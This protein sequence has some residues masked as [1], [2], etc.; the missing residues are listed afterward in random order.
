M[1]VRFTELIDQTNACLMSL[2]EEFGTTQKIIIWH[3]TFEKLSNSE[4]EAFLHW[5]CNGGVVKID[6]RHGAKKTEPGRVSVCIEKGMIWKSLGGFAIPARRKARRDRGNWM[7]MALGAL[8]EKSMQEA[9]E[10]LKATGYKFAEENSMLKY[11]LENRLFSE[12]DHK[13]IMD[14]MPEAE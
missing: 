8:V 5:I 10:K 7:A 13:K 9:K 14:L 12:A 2:H 4:V 11:C 1:S 6:W 3:H